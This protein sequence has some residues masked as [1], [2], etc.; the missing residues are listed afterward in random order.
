MTLQGSATA[1]SQLH[2]TLDSLDALERAEET[3]FWTRTKRRLTAALVRRYVQ[4]GDPAIVDI[5]CG[6]GSLIASLER[7]FPRGR[8]CGVDGYAEALAN[9]RKRSATA[10]LIL[11]DITRLESIGDAGTYDAATI[12]DV[13][14]HLDEPERTLEG[15]K[16]WLRDGGIVIASVPAH[17][18]LW[19]D[20]DVFLGHR[21]RYAKHELTGLLRR[22][23]YRVLHANYLFAPLFLP[24]LVSRKLL[25]P[26]RGRTGKDMEA[27]ELRP[28]PILNGAMT[29]I[30]AA[31]VR[32]SLSLP[33][34]FG[35]SVYCVAR[36]A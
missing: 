28:M 16:P 10:R 21:K 32:W 6:N 7:L 29:A 25:A 12:L 11:G 3:H 13:L 17:M 24:A 23:G 15:L 26:L 31:E 36:K 5:G 34:P 19:S 20:R 18:L 9:A 30:E 1:S 35:T 2:F 4:K 8:F 22:C 27:T 14:E 33:V